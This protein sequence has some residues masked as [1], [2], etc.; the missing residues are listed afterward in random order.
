MIQYRVDFKSVPWISP[1]KGVREKVYRVGHRQLRLV[2]YS[3]DMPP[4]WC[5]KG[6]FGYVLGGR[7]EIAF[8][9]ELHVYSSGDGIFLPRGSDHKHMAKALTDTVIVVFAEDV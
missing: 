3:K 7:M 2:E 5:E 8:E 6:H 9:N 4:H 1:A